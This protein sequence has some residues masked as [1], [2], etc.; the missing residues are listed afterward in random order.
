MGPIPIRT[1]LLHKFPDIET[2]A[3]IIR[4]NKGLPLSW[5]Q[6]LFFQNCGRST[7]TKPVIFPCIR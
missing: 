4:T 1:D 7:R 2:K 3:Q 5:R 6:A